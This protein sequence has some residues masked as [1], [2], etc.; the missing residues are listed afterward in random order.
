MGYVVYLINREIEHVA[1]QN[2]QDAGGN[3]SMGVS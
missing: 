3:G 2:L 1:N